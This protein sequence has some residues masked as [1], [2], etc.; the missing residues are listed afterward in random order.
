MYLGENYFQLWPQPRH[1]MSTFNPK[2]SVLHH[3][4][5]REISRR[6][7]WQ[8]SKLRSDCPVPCSEPRAATSP[9]RKPRFRFRAHK[10]MTVLRNEISKGTFEII[11][12]FVLSFVCLFTSKNVSEAG[13][14]LFC[15]LIPDGQIAIPRTAQRHTKK[16][17][18]ASIDCPC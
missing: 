12:I 7:T 14:T 13:S 3:C 6:L 10:C 17:R 9:E 15:S 2:F 1:D 18:R 4:T 16:W 11:L 5:E 8:V